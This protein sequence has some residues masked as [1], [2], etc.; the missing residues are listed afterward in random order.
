MWR[1]VVALG[2]CV[3]LSGC[4]FYLNPQCDDQIRNG[5]E[6]GIDCGGTCGRCE[7]GASCKVNADCEDSDCQSGVCTAFPCFNHVRDGDETDVD[8][9]GD[10]RT[11]SGGRTCGGD[12]DCASGTCTPSTSTCAG[13]A[14]SFDDARTYDAGAKPYALFT[15][16]IDGDGDLDL[17][18]ADEIN[19][20]LVVLTND[21]LGGFQNSA[22]FTT[23]EFPTGGA[24]GDFDHDGVPDVVTAD[25][26]GNSVSVLGN[27]G[28]TLSP[29]ASYGTVAGAET[30]NLAVGDLDGDGNLDVVATNPQKASVS[31]FLG[32]PDGTLRAAVDLPVGITGAAQPYSAA[33]ADFDGDG[34]LDL[35]IAD[36]LS[37]QIIVRLGNGNATFGPEVA[38]ADRGTPP[39]ILIT[40]DVNGDGMADLVCANRDSDN[41]SV[42]LGR[43]NGTFRSAIVA[44][45]GT[46]SA[47]YSVAVADFNQDGV[48]DIVTGDYAPMLDI[49]LN[50]ASVLLGIGNGDFEPPLVVHGSPTYGVSV[51]DF[52][53]DGKPD[54]GAANF[55]A[56]TVTVQLNTSQ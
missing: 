43:G 51:G 5:D 17:V 4:V 41:V 50:D 26:H 39:L 40:A 42:L 16:D 29:R 14:L 8:C 2:T 46:G 21:G 15:V 38:Y 45:T 7:I 56:H 44:S 19:S 3:G 37:A 20:Q 36:S 35:A 9:G 32:N 28:G 12:A 13:L 55:S 10:C 33:I 34:K 1:L 27:A 24:I 47:P 6:T 25:Y 23:G 54:F 31:V 11:C 48:L 49:R 18:S 22:M 52:N 30:S 53:G